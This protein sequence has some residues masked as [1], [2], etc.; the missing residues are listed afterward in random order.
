MNVGAQ[1]SLGADLEADYLRGLPFLFP[2]LREI[3]GASHCSAVF[4]SCV[5][6]SHTTVFWEEVWRLIDEALGIAYLQAQGGM[7][8][9]MLGTSSNPTWRGEGE[10]TSWE[11]SVCGGFVPCAG[12]ERPVTPESP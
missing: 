2:L 3:L 10:Q 9:N 1:G 11:A 8:S 7:H 12:K 4:L 5:L 6:I